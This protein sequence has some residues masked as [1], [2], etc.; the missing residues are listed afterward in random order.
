VVKRGAFTLI[1]LIFAIII[2]GITVISLPMMNQL[3]SKNI[4]NNLIQEAVFAAAT[5]LNEVTTAQWDENST[6]KD[7]TSSIAKVI[8][9]DNSCE[10]N[11]S[12]NRYRLRP[13]HI[14]ESLHRKCLNDLSATEADT[15]SDDDVTAIEDIVHGSQEIFLNPTPSAEGY[16][17]D[18]N[19][20]LTV[21]YSP[22]FNHANQ[23]NMKKITSTIFDKNGNVIVKLSTYVANIGEVDYYKRTF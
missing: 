7:S 16:K 17:S 1:E 19:S 18:Y 3:L 14:L 5:E 15:N 22:E 10:D 11:S 13:G 23:P 9:L 12:S 4:D 21:S 6:E 20:T 2:I 8:N